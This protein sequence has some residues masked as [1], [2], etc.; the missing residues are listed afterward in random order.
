MASADPVVDSPDE[1]LPLIGY[2]IYP[3]VD[4]PISPAPIGRQWMDDTPSRFAYRCLPLTL[5]NQ[6]GWIIQNPASFSAR[7]NGGRDKSAVAIVFD[8]TP[9][10]ER[11]SS[12]FG[13]GVITFHLPFLFRTPAGFNLWVKGPTNEPKDGIAP[14]EGLV[15]TDWTSASF[16]MNWK[17]TRAHHIV[18]FERGEPICMLLPYPRHLLERFDP[19]CLPLQSAPEVHQAYRHWSEQRDEFQRRTAQGDE[20]AIR[21]GWQKD[22]FQGKDPGAQRVEDH[23]T[24][25]QVSPF[26]APHR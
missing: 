6:A 7:W 5:A 9:P 14:L 23:Q 24:K 17:I 16:T 22:Y 21:R 4:M 8:Q 26:H 15:E 18:R 11:I 20:D 2:E 1:R 10:D 13:S 3:P 12:L 25:L 19:V